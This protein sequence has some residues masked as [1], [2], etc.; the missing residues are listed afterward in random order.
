MDN[1]DPAV[2]SVDLQAFLRG[3]DL[4]APLG[5][6][7]IGELAGELEIRTLP[8]GAVLF[9]QGDAAD[10]LYIVRSGGLAAYRRDAEA[11]LTL[12]GMIGSGEVP[13][14]ISLIARTARTSLVRAL[15]DS[16][17]LRLSA[18]AFHRL[19]GKYPQAMLH[20]VGVTA[21]HLLERRPYRSR[22]SWW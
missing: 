16:I 11:A 6:A 13:G 9:D 15:R 12:L 1:T 10:A 14:E 7:G 22:R 17:V 21:R 5:A 20:T 4:F 19:V 18:D 8:G 2:P 3:I